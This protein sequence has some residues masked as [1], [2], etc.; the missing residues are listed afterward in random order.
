MLPTL[1]TRVLLHAS[2]VMG[3]ATVSPVFSP[4]VGS[5]WGF[6]SPHA[7][8][9][10][11]CLPPFLHLATE[12]KALKGFVS[13]DSRVCKWLPI[14]TNMSCGCLNVLTGSV[15]HTDSNMGLLIN[16]SI[17]RSKRHEFSKVRL[18]PPKAS[19][20]EEHAYGTSK[21]LFFLPIDQTVASDGL[22]SRVSSIAVHGRLLTADSNMSI[23]WDGGAGSASFVNDSNIGWG[24]NN[25]EIDHSPIPDIYFSLDL[26]QFSSGEWDGNIPIVQHGPEHDSALCHVLISRLHMNKQSVH[27]SQLDDIPIN[28]FLYVTCES[29]R[30]R[31][32]ALRPVS[33]KSFSD[34]VSGVWASI[35][36]AVL[37]FHLL[38][39]LLFLIYFGPVR[40]FISS[41]SG[42]TI[43]D[44]AQF[45]VH[46]LGTRTT[47]FG[48]VIF[49]TIPVQAVTCPT[50]NDQLAGCQGG[51]ACP[52]LAAT[53][54]N[55]GLIAGTVA[56]GYLTVQAL[57]PQEW[58][59]VFKKSVLDFFLVVARRPAPGSAV[60]CSAFA[61]AD[62]MEAHRNQS[63]PK[64]DI[65]CALL[66]RAGESTEVGE[67]NQITN[68]INIIK[69]ESSTLGAA[70]NARV[71]EC[72][73]TLQLLW[74]YCGRVTERST[75]LVTVETDDESGSTSRSSRASTKLVR[76][77]TQ[78]QFSEIISVFQTCA[79]AL[80]VSNILQTSEFFRQVVF[81]AVARD[82][83]PWQQAHELVLVYFFDVDNSPSLHISTVYASGAQDTR[84]A[85]ALVNAKQHYPNLVRGGP[86]KNPD[87]KPHNPALGP[88]I[89]GS[90]ADD[91]KICM[92]FNLGTSHSSRHVKDGC[93]IFRHVCDQ[94]VSDKG[95]NGRCEGNHS[96]KRCDN[97]QKCDKA[98]A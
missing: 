76:P 46:V 13:D 98:V 17:I 4:S 57:L 84:R 5:V 81:D 83:I 3:A 36:K 93:C 32:L 54:A 74:A 51:A 72:V 42:Y 58:R 47:I 89:P 60:D 41:F 68:I 22:D 43:F 25:V 6:H 73:G 33:G 8:R 21:H 40:F 75:A 56:T 85:R 35:L 26:L 53:N 78:F 69:M 19:H 16:K 12:H 38:S 27:L 11:G 71:G 79:H 88:N 18:S 66:S 65:L 49:F 91:A 87:D 45:A 64:A 23:G 30:N 77:K 94:W 34:Y 28:H 31:S 82:E 52:F 63:A 61:V 29:Q 70:A 67:Q 1:T 39:L 20:L 86:P 90:K 62:L 44:A 15:M 96:R 59:S 24:W 97:P 55:A 7:P 37:I 92:S 9:S 48:I 10:D 50:C 80:G 95:P 14:K 2:C